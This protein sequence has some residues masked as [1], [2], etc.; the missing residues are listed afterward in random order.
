MAG[1]NTFPTFF[2]NPVLL[3]ALFAKWANLFVGVLDK[4]GILGSCCLVAFRT[5]FKSHNTAL[6]RKEVAVAVLEKC[7][8]ASPAVGL[9]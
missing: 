9:R 8:L 2:A 7:L 4:Y 6:H 5:K 1:V 3:S